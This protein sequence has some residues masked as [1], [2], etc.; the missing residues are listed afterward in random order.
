MVWEF[1]GNKSC[2]GSFCVSCS[3]LGGIYFVDTILD[4][5]VIV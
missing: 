3:R 1:H 5:G 4:I 2:E